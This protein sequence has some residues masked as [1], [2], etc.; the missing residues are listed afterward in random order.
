MPRYSFE[1]GEYIL[2]YSDNGEVVCHMD[3]VALAL[4]KDE[5]KMWT[6]HKHGSRENVQN[7]YDKIV[8]RY[9]AA[10]LHDIADEMV[11]I[12]GKFPVDELNR[13]IESSGYI[14][15]MCQKLGL[16]V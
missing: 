12:A 16:E 8:K 10:G 2:F 5:P 3:E 15:V 7:W 4:S 1:N 11:M 9:R 6:L 13:C 14:R